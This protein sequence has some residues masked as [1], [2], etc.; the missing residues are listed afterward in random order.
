[1]NRQSFGMSGNL[2]AGQSGKT[3]YSVH[4]DWDL[5][6]LPGIG[7][8]AVDED[9]A[10][11]L[12][13]SAF[14][15]IARQVT[16]RS[17]D[18]G[19]LADGLDDAVEM[20][21]HIY[22]L[23]ALEGRGLLIRQP[24]E[25][26]RAEAVSAEAPIAVA[27]GNLSDLDLAHLTAAMRAN[28]MAPSTE[29]DA[30][31]AVLFVADYLQEGVAE[32]VDRFAAV[33]L[34]TC[35]CKPQGR[36]LWIGPRLGGPEGA[37]PGCLHESLA[38]NDRL[39]IF[40]E[41]LGIDRDLRRSR[42]RLLYAEALAAAVLA[43]ALIPDSPVAGT[44]ITL[45]QETLETT[46]HVIS[47]RPS[48]RRCGPQVQPPPT[49]LT[50]TSVHDRDTDRLVEAETLLARLEH[51]I[52]PITGCVRSVR[53]LPGSGP[54]HLAAAEHVFLHKPGDAPSFFKAL[55]MASGGKGSTATGARLAALCEALERY[56]GIWQGYETRI[57][58][59]FADIPGAIS[60]ELCAQ[61]SPAQY[62]DRDELNRRHDN[63]QRIPEP[64][65]PGQPLYWT[66][67]RSLVSGEVRYLPTAYCYYGGGSGLDWRY[68][69][70]DSNGIA[71]GSDLVEATLHG[72]LEL[73]ERDAVA[74]WWYN[75]IQRPGVDVAAFEDSL[76]D[77]ICA[78]FDDLGRDV[79]VLDI[80]NDLE[81]PVFVAVSACRDRDR[82]DIVYG[83]G[84]HPDPV[85]GIR[86]ALMELT[87]TLPC[88]ADR[89]PDGSTAYRPINS[90][91]MVWWENAS[92]ASQR[93]LCPS[94]GPMRGPA[95]YRP[96]PPTLRA[97]VE[98][99]IDG[100]AARGFDVLLLD[101]SR[102]NIDLAVAKVLVPGLRHFW[103]RF[104]PGRLYDVPVAL[105]WQGAP[106][107]EHQLNPLPIF[108]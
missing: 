49:G 48:C 93:Y 102:P 27:V 43:R 37:C 61:W 40:L 68:F 80:T 3:R 96:A 87:Q 24:T 74:I 86:A 71:A 51:H 22:A 53:P 12:V 84:A 52:D 77:A 106:L 54:L 44:L 50:F 26:A 5:R 6:P 38:Q 88:V 25:A 32:A 9:R 81:M 45:D 57:H 73:F 67:L 90:D 62:G 100:L 76:I 34:A 59:A 35:L 85:S 105:G 108:F 103:M 58:G 94:P 39:R 65:P 7:L 29:D 83:F 41:E 79:R 101:Q 99:M 15:R 2:A 18:A 23:G 31:I 75:R 46:H 107:A 104:G 66:P 4:P 98:A 82:E 92:R 36:N 72:L 56:S 42:R 11:Y 30:Q 10:D 64:L 21:N 55:Y 60:P 70:S 16:D 19:L 91:C 69:Y 14:E 8:V 20:A 95:D 78:H 33:G 97:R 89:N 13:G 17:L 47:R 1:M 28:G 63:F